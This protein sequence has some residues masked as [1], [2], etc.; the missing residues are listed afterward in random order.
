MNSISSFLDKRPEGSRLTLTAVAATV[1]TATAL[2]GYQRLTRSR[3]E[4]D[5]SAFHQV[6][7]EEKPSGPAIISLIDDEMHKTVNGEEANPVID[8]TLV[9][10]LL[11]RNI[12]FFGEEGVRKIRQSYVVVLGA[13]AIGSW[14]ALM[15]VRSGLGH[16]RIVDR[17]VIGV[18]SLT[19]HAVAKVSDVGQSK[20][21]IMKRYLADIAPQAKVETKQAEVNVH[22][23]DTLILTGSRKPDFVVDTLTDVKDKVMLA[24]Y[25]REHDIQIVSAMSAG[26]KADPSLI[27]MTD[28]NLTMADPLARMYR[29]QL[30]KLG[31]DRGVPVVYSI[32][33]NVHMGKEKVSE[34]F[35]R[36]SL[37][38]LSPVA[39]M[40]GMALTTYI[41]VQLAEFTAYKL[42]TNKM[43][44]GVYARMQKEL[45]SREEFVFNNTGVY[46]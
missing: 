1:L 2:L 7:K 24:Q 16:I 28:V 15:L 20:S 32:E 25:C 19:R 4:Q 9:E 46:F 8:E 22:S 10:E 21:L 34:D 36:R 18:D 42:P 41:L 40:F 29:R 27:Q 38:I 37:P 13:G 33:K 30:R 45:A 31:I 17:G 23:L 35:R 6:I 44:D 5:K 39:S 12:A 26:S 14:T 43:R 11:A 3:I